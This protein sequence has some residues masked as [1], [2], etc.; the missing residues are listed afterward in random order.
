MS[1]SRSRSF[2][3][4]NRTVLAP[5]PIYSLR[6]G[7]PPP[8]QTLVDPP[9]QD[10]HDQLLCR[11]PGRRLQETVRLDFLF[12]LNQ[13]SCPPRDGY[14][15]DGISGLL[16]VFLSRDV[17]TFL[18]GRSRFGVNAFPMTNRT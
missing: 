12:D 6:A 7:F 4:D 10:A 17:D 1:E 5:T 18:G 3:F 11:L 8:G 16:P 15:R 9:G 2:F 13:P 14:A